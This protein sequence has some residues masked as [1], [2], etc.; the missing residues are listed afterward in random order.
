MFG[1]KRKEKEI[2]TIYVSSVMGWLPVRVCPASCAMTVGIGCSAQCDAEQDEAGLH[3][4]ISLHLFSR[5]GLFFT[6]WATIQF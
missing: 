4:W 1:W 6:V 2:M 5:R 3:G